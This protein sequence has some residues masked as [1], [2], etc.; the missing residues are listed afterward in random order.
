MTLHIQCATP[1]A[2][3]LLAVDA[4]DGIL[5]FPNDP[6]PWPGLGLKVDPLLG[7]NNQLK[8][9]AIKDLGACGNRIEIWQGYSSPMGGATEEPQTTLYV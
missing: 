8:D 3:L 4:P 2:T 9:R 6:S 5:R 7:I 1:F